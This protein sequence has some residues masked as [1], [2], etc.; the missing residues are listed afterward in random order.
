M[1]TLKS[2]F[3][4]FLK[5]L[6]Q[7][8]EKIAYLQL[9]G[10]LEEYLVKEFCYYVF[11]NSKGKEFAVINMGG[12]K[13]KEQEIDICILSGRNLDDPEIKFMIEA[14]YFRNKHRFRYN[15]T[16]EITTTLKSL[17]SQMHDSNVE[18]HGWFKV[19]PYVKKIF[20][21]VFLS[22]ISEEK[23]IQ[24]K[25]KYYQRIIKTAKENLNNLKVL[26]NMSEDVYDDIE[27]KL[28]NKTFFV[29]LKA[30]LW[31]KL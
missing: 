28:I 26:D 20:G 2:T 22:Y 17:N 18:T 13:R 16:D 8:K 5:H 7:Q 30:G 24:E 21:L 6:N 9:I 14:K 1:E 15:A 3:K 4:P 25:E 11:L 10:K 23:N 19:S 29:T 27:V 12:R 31:E